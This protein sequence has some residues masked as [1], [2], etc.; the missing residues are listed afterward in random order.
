M[1]TIDTR[2]SIITLFDYVA[3]S[4][5]LHQQI[6][7]ADFMREVGL[8]CTAVVGVWHTVFRGP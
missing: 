8:R 1:M 5:P 6:L 7:I 2:D 3:A 4:K